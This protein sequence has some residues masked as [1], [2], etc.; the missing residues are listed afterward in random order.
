MKHR[1]AKYLLFVFII[2]AVLASTSVA[3]AATKSKIPKK[4]VSYGH[5]AT[6]KGILK[7]QGKVLA[8][9]TLILERNG[10]IYKNYTTNKYGRVSAKVGGPHKYIW[11]W[12]F[13]G[14][15]RYDPSSSKPVMTVPDWKK[16]TVPQVDS[17]S[18]GASYYKTVKLL[19]RRYQF[20]FSTPCFL[21]FRTPVGAKTY[22]VYYE[23]PL[24]QY[25]TTSHVLKVPLN[26]KYAFELGAVPTTDSNGNTVQPP[27]KIV[28]KYW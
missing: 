26:G 14:K 19:E 18:S 1:F 27:A 3:Q 6:Y 4:V 9:Y 22:T 13:A 25:T 21:R 8:G 2:V 12:W 10:K 15:G 16:L 7:S 5:P 28:I 20:Y 17:D 23:D 11:Q 24:G